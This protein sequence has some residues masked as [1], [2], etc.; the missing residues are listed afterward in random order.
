[1]LL[2]HPT[3]LI[4]LIDL[5]DADGYPIGQSV[6]VTVEYVQT[7]TQDYGADTDGRQGMPIIEYDLLDVSLDTVTL[8]TLTIAQAE[9]AIAEARAVFHQRNRRTTRRS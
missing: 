5:T 7:I 3:Q 2:N 9:S 1:M 8:R 4:I 6:P